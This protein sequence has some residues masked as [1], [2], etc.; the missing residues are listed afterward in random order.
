MN[1]K[2]IKSGAILSYLLIFANTFYG[3]FFV[4]FLISRL[5]QGEYGVY[6]IIQSFSG[7]LSIA[8]FGISTFIVRNIVY[9]KTQ[10]EEEKKENFLFFA[11]RFTFIAAL[12]ILA[13]GGG[14]YPFLDKIS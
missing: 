6:K 10:N 2:E 13:C 8:S 14:M 5:G 11:I 9:F 3:L 12:F 1:T 7:Q 4:P